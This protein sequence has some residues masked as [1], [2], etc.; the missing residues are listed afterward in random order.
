MGRKVRARIK[1]LQVYLLRSRILRRWLRNDTVLA[2]T[3]YG[4]F[5]RR[6]I[7]VEGLKAHGNVFYW[8]CHVLMIASYWVEHQDLFTGTSEV[9]VPLGAIT[10]RHL[11]L[12]RTVEKN[13]STAPN[14][15][16]LFGRSA[17]GFS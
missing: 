14:W 8:E 12:F 17:V 13:V 9:L 5:T 15:E 11:R 1:P 4:S 2:Y 6:N 16:A 10:L 7:S 3:F